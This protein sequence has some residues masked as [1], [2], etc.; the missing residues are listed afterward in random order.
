MKWS[1]CAAIYVE[2]SLRLRLQR[3]LG[4][5]WPASTPCQIMAEVAAPIRAAWEEL[6]RQAAQGGLFHNDDTSMRVLA[7]N[8]AQ[9]RRR[10]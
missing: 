2:R 5:P 3:S 9:A 4:I 1:R 6:I 8:K 7:L 10:R